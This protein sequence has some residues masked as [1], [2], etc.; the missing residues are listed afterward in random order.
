MY[1]D[2]VAYLPDDILVKL[3]RASMGVSLEARVPLLDHR[4]IEFA[5]RLP[6]SL[7][8]RGGGK[9]IMRR[10]LDRYVPRRLVDRPKRGF[11]MP[12][13]DWLRGSLRPWAEELLDEKRLREGGVIEP[14]PVRRKWQEH[15][16]GV[17]RWDYHLW[18]VLMLQ[19]WMDTTATSRS[20][21]TD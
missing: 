12:I 8:L 11:H 10:V 14:E 16:T 4:V 9:W 15:L 3:D 13:A 21:V 18:T 5:W 2:T 7:K 19:A 1:L 17:S 6:L 20:L